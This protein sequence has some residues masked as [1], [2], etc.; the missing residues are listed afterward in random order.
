MLVSSLM[1]LTFAEFTPCVSEM[2][3]AKFAP[4]V[5]FTLSPLPKPMVS[6][7]SPSVT[8]EVGSA[9]TSEAMAWLAPSGNP[10]LPPMF[11]TEVPA[12]RSS[13][14]MLVRPLAVGSALATFAFRMPSPA[15]MLRMNVG[16]R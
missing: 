9:L 13:I 14:V 2:I 6:V 3:P 11:S 16:P 4:A 5:P 7:F 12:P 15:T 8:L 1:M 10:A